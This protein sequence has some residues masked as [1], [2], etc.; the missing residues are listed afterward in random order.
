[1]PKDKTSLVTNANRRNAQ[2]GRVM[3]AQAFSGCAH[4]S[5]TDEVGRLN[6]RAAEKLQKSEVTNPLR[7]ILGTEP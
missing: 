4:M 7:P 5:R 3:S 1:M 2:G 6:F